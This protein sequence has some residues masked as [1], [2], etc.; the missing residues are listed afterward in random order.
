ML[1]N[2]SKKIFFIAIAIL[3]AFANFF[4]WQYFQKEN[5]PLTQ[6]IPYQCVSYDP[7]Y[8]FGTNDMVDVFFTEEMINND[9]K[10]ISEKAKCVRIYRTTNGMTSVPKI[11]QKY[12]LT[13]IAG[14]WLSKNEILN[15]KEIEILIQM[16]NDNPGTITHALVGSE[17]LFSLTIPT[18][19]LIGYLDEVRSRV[20][21]PVGTAEQEDDWFLNPE[22]ADHID[23]IAAHL[24]PYWYSI[25]N[26]DAVDWV[27]EKYFSLSS[28]FTGKP[29]MIAEVGWPSIGSQRKGAIT[30]IS[31]QA[32]FIKEFVERAEKNNINYNLMEAFDQP[33]KINSKEGRAGAH[34]GIIDTNGKFKLSFGKSSLLW[35]EIATLLG[36]LLN[37]I[38]IFKFFNINLKGQLLGQIIL[39]LV[40]SIIVLFFQTLVQEY[41]IWSWF[42]WILLIPTLIILFFIVFVQTFETAEVVGDRPLLKLKNVACKMPDRLPFVSIHLPCCNEDSCMVIE[43]IKSLLNLDYP[44][45]EIIVI[46]NNTIDKNL[47]QPVEKFCKEYSDK[48][49]FYHLERLADFKAGALNFGLEVSD[50]KAKIIGVVDSDY[51]VKSSWLKEAIPFFSDHRIAVVQAPQAYNYQNTIFETAL[52]DEYDGFFKIG[53]VQR[54]EKNAIIQHGTMML[55][56][57]NILEQVGRWSET[58]ITEDAELGLKILEHGYQIYYLNKEF[59]RGIIPASF[60][61]YQKQRFRW[62]YGAIRIIINHAK[63][64]F[65]KSKLTFDQRYHFLAGWLPWAGEG[66]YPVFSVLALIGTGLILWEPRYFPPIVF[67]YPLFMHMIVRALMIFL[68]YRKRMKIGLKRTFFSMIAGASLVTVIAKAFWIGLFQFNQPFRKTE[69]VLN[70]KRLGFFNYLVSVRFELVISSTLVVGA[71]WLLSIH[72]FFHKEAVI[73][74]LALLIQTIPYFCTIYLMFIGNFMPQRCVINKIITK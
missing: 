40:A 39:Q 29:I 28:Y 65:G 71:V 17:S 20:N 33:W 31:E 35:A 15:E 8:H 72:G 53:M 61:E 68:N 41:M 63:Q 50:H 66:L 43:S 48:I 22:L 49:K 38:F 3:V 12:G 5:V 64:F 9:L 74:S 59:G 32:N 18:N 55:V 52:N 27:F 51:Q 42:V 30:G 10:L 1:S 47:W 57:K 62:V 14:A 69:K 56:Q 73:W 13:V 7:H 24:L 26:E 46:D 2:L 19:T 34:W 44:N 70:K 67:I 16:V 58:S 37:F 36:L 6:P 60:T 4:I 23:F 54:N 45:F 21:V 11:A 25:S